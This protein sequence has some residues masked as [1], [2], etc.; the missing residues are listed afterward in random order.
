[1]QMKTLSL[2]IPAI[3]LT[4]LLAGCSS[5]GNSYIGKEYELNKV[6]VLQNLAGKT[7]DNSNFP[8]GL[9]WMELKVNSTTMN[10][11]TGCNTMGGPVYATSDKIYFGNIIST[12]MYCEGVNE[13]G[14][15]NALQNARTW[16]IENDRL[17]LYDAPGGIVL[18][19][20]KEGEVPKTEPQN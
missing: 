1:M 19:V 10:G 12:R 20:F 13:Q 14:F 8:N 16:T 6:W 3:A 15:F 18:A 7:A 2:L 5:S 11:S 4:L 17:F 9:P